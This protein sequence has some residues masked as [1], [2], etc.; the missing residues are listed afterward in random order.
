MQTGSVYLLKWRLSQNF[1]FG[2]RL[3]GQGFS[4]YGKK[5]RGKGILSG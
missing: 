2:D 3:N 4:C 5:I 1:S